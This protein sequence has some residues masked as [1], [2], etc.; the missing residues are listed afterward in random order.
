MHH[1]LDISTS[2]HLK[3]ESDNSI[4]TCADPESF[5]RGGQQRGANSDNLF[6]V[7]EGR[8]DPNLTISGSSSARHLNAVSLACRCWPNI[9][10]WF[11]RFVIFQGPDQFC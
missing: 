11:G 9:E 2:N 1:N 3:Y 8:E 4:I 6:L 10:S 5:V 7:N